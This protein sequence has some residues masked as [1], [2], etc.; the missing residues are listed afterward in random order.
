MLSSGKVLLLLSTGPLRH[1]DAQ[2]HKHP[3]ATQHSTG[4]DSSSG[5]VCGNGDHA[6]GHLTDTQ[7]PSHT[8]L[9]PGCDCTHLIDQVD[10]AK[11]ASIPNPPAPSAAVNEAAHISTWAPNW[12]RE[13]EGSKCD[14]LAYPMNS[15]NLHFDAALASRPCS[16]QEDPFTE[17]GG[18]L[19]LKMVCKLICALGSASLVG[20]SRPRR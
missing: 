5:S 7:R 12:V 11:T 17:A 3:A 19:W 18:L 13:V 14:L 8:T 9:T 20:K 10:N 4:L 1:I 6:L 15:Y 2:C 16:R